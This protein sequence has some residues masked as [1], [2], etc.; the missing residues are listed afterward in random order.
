[1]SSL[2]NGFSL[3]LH[4]QVEPITFRVSA[5]KCVLVGGLAKIEV[6]GDSRPFLFTFFVANEVKLHPTDSSR[7]DEFIKK[8]AGGMLTP[9]LEPG[10]ERMEQLGEF[11]THVIDIEGTGWKEA[12]ADIS[13]TG[14]G[15]IAV[16]GAGSVKVRISVPKGIGIAVRPPLMPFDIWE[17]AA[18]YTGS[19]AVRKT[20]K[21]KS[22]NRRKGV[23]RN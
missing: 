14:L 22:G 20:T 21:T 16:T 3:Q 18:K 12:A 8:H 2:T 11:D 23:G 6:I 5:G 1:V 10:P 13:L 4:R 9:P 19:K 15:W 17:V 7:A